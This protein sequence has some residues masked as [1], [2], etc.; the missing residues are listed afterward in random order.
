MIK[1]LLII[2]ALYLSACSPG[3]HNLKP[4][5]NQN[6]QNLAELTDN[7]RVILQLYAPLLQ[8]SG[9][10]LI[11]QHIGKTYQELF[12]ISAADFTPKP[13]DTWDKLFALIP[14]PDTDGYK[15]RFQYVTAALARGISPEEQQQL[16]YREGWIYTACSGD[17]SPQQASQLLD[18][19][20]SISAEPDFYAQA[21]QLLM[22]I[23]PILALRRNSL[24]HAM[25]L[26]TVLTKQL[27]QQLTT[28]QVH[29]QSIMQFSATEVDG[30]KTIDSTLKSLDRSELESILNKLSEKYLDNPSYKDAAIDLMID[31]I[32]TILDSQLR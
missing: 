19:L 29:A 14:E 3:V 9:E 17:F 31:G 18:K 7:V 21:E 25:N 8:A 15:K 6:Q 1:Y 2:V 23:D 30:Q 16:K 24:D 4:V 12:A 27:E 10:S 5:A 32:K 26:F 28:A 11:I 22:E 20:D 13:S